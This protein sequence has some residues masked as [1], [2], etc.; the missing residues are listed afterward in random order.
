MLKFQ[1]QARPLWTFISI[2]SQLSRN[3]WSGGIISHQITSELH[4]TRIHTHA[5]NSF[6]LFD[7]ILNSKN[8]PLC[9]RCAKI[10]LNQCWQ[11][12]QYSI[13]L[14]LKQFSWYREVSSTLFKAFGEIFFA[15]S[16][17]H[18]SRRAWQGKD[19]VWSRRR[20]E[21]FWRG[22]DHAMSAVYDAAFPP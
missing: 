20:G 8:H 7:R 1:P 17:L 15:V 16:P 11:I 18:F 14:R 4:E 13:S 19:N 5:E 6:L 9:G 22:N 12:I 2:S 21:W 10:S 3:S